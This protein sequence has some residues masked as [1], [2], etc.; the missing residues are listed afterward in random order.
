M[1]FLSFSNRFIGTWKVQKGKNE[2]GDFAK[3]QGIASEPVFVLL[4]LMKDPDAAK[5]IFTNSNWPLLCYLI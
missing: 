5:V 4:Q 1:M 3:I 2:L